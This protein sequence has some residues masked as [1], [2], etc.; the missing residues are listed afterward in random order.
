MR[1]TLHALALLALLVPASTAHAQVSFGIRIGAPPAPRVYRVPRSPG[2]DYVW[3]EGYWYPQGSRY[4]WH[5]GYWTRP[6]YEGAYWV[7]PYYVGG[8]YFPGQWE[9]RRGY[10]AHD[11][12]WDR[13]RQRDERRGRDPRDYDRNDRRR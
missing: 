7:E 9:G 1:K 13:G 6:P 2:P 11:H 3:V 12:R 5:N 10:L 8:R 4:M